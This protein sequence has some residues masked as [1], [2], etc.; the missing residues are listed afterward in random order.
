MAMM[1]H[2][3]FFFEVMFGTQHRNPKDY[4]FNVA[5]ICAS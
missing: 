5:R 3:F 1:Q 2:F 4:N